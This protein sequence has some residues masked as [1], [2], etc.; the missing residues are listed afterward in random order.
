MMTTPQNVAPFYEG[1]RIA[2][3]RL[4]E[5]V[6]GLS[7]EQLELRAAPHLWPIWAITAHT[8]GVRPYWLCH[9]C[10][11]PGAERT[12]FA[13]FIDEGWEDDLS[14]PREARE[15][16]SALESTWT[17]VEDC[18][19]RWTPDMLQDTFRRDTNGKVTIH[20]RQSVLIRLLTHDAYHCGEIAQT[21]GMH[22]LAEVDI[23]TGRVPIVSSG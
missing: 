15:L 20:T 4:V 2:Q 7:P 17:I 16:V 18:L 12:P 8:A 19:D 14:H 22:G 10:K 23:W 5:R 1:W 9:I 13:G 21:L 11:E 6:S 3:D